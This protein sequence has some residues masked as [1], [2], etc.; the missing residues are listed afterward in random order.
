MNDNFN[1]IHLEKNW[2]I[3]DLFDNDDFIEKILPQGD[4]A[5]LFDLGVDLFDVVG[6]VFPLEETHDCEGLVLRK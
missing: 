2:K 3:Y 4:K 6:L 5:G 1:L